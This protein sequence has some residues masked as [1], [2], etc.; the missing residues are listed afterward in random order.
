MFEIVDF[1]QSVAYRTW[2]TTQCFFTP[3]SAC[4]YFSTFAKYNHCMAQTFFFSFS[5]SLF[6]LGEL[7]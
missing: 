2:I 1:L 6:Y 3:L 4:M 7:E 5:H